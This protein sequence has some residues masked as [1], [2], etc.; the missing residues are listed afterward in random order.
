VRWDSF[1]DFQADKGS[2]YLRP[3]RTG[4]YEDDMWALRGFLA[5]PSTR[6][7]REIE[8]QAMPS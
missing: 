5:N 3:A 4:S 1:A 8:V 2:R 6:W 7:K